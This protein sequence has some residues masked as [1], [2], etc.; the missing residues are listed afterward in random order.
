MLDNRD[1]FENLFAIHLEETEVDFLPLLHIGGDRV[2]NGRVLSKG[3]RLH[4]RKE[5]RNGKVME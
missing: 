4:L 1:L 3:T 5:N 2:E